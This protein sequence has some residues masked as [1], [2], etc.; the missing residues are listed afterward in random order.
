MNEIHKNLD[1]NPSLNT[2]CVLDMSKVFDKV[3]HKGLLFKLKTYGIDGD[4]L[5][6][7]ENYLSGCKQRVVLIGKNH[8]YGVISMQAFLKDL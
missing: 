7:L 3:W 2:S 4:L 1:A 8:P 6:L 5:K